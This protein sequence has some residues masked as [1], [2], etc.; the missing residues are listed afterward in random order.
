MEEVTWII[1][2]HLTGTEARPTYTL[3][4]NNAGSFGYGQVFYFLFSRLTTV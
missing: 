2:E 4:V 1:R 3:F